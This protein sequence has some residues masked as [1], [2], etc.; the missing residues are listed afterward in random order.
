MSLGSELFQG[1]PSWN[2]CFSWKDVG[3]VGELLSVLP[4]PTSLWL[5]PSLSS[6]RYG[7]PYLLQRPEDDGECEGY[8]R[9]QE[10]GLRDDSEEELGLGGP[11][12][13]SQE[14]SPSGSG[15]RKLGRAG[16][17]GKTLES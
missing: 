10:N 2:F 6:A 4:V 12:R 3:V 1:F 14:T 11:V 5:C 9:A 15:L 16:K 7:G 13:D 17:S 8:A